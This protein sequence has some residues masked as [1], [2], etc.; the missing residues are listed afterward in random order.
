MN[1][2]V[3][4]ALVE[5]FK[6]EAV[7]WKQI[8]IAEAVAGTHDASVL[9]ALADWLGHQDRHIRGNVAFIFFGALVSVSEAA[10]AAIAKLQ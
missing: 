8:G 4:G 1:V 6:N 9:P 2:S 5:Q 10:K 3:H 7:Y